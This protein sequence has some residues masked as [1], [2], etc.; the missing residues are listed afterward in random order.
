MDLLRN[1]FVIA[2]PHQRHACCH[3]PFVE[4]LKQWNLVLSCTR[5]G[6]PLTCGRWTDSDWVTLVLPHLDTAHQWSGMT[7]NRR[8]NYSRTRNLEEWLHDAFACHQTLA[9]NCTKPHTS[10][11]LLTT[12]ATQSQAACR[13]VCDPVC[14]QPLGRGLAKLNGKACDSHYVSLYLCSVC[15]KYW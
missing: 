4:V 8:W 2:T 7:E 9:F 15:F 12:A 10:R 13:W 1:W 5:P 6:W 11:M 14:E 3:V